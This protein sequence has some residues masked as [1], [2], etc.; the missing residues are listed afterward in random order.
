MCEVDM[1]LPLFF[2]LITL[3]SFLFPN[4]IFFCE[5]YTF[6]VDQ[7]ADC[8]NWVLLPWHMQLFHSDRDFKC[9][10]FLMM[11]VAT[12]LLSLGWAVPVISI[13]A[14]QSCL[15]SHHLLSFQLSL[16]V[17]NRFPPNF[18]CS[19][20]SQSCCNNKATTT[21]TWIRTISWTSCACASVTVK[22]TGPPQCSAHIHSFN[23]HISIEKLGVRPR[24][25]MKLMVG[26]GGWTVSKWLKVQWVL[27]KGRALLNSMAGNLELREDFPCRS[28]ILP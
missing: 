28:H 16:W 9:R 17:I 18:T 6:P 24:A 14:P 12:G 27:K 23:Q 5:M 22:H 3:Y 20:V 4:R 25:L 1:C 8:A 26:Q 11:A 13:P 7:G 21:K 15:T 2:Y 19:L 10:N